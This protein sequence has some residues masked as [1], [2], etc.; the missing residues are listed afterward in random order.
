M[1]SQNKSACNFMVSRSDCSRHTLNR[2][3]D[4]QRL[5]LSGRLF[6]LEVLIGRLL[7]EELLRFPDKGLLLAQIETD[8]ERESKKLPPLAAAAAKD[9]LTRIRVSSRARVVHLQKPDGLS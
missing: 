1:A 2:M 6:A 9:T 7:T 4:S 8:V 3:T 5:E